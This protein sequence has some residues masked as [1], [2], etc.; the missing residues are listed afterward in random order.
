MFDLSRARTGVSYSLPTLLHSFLLSLTL[1]Y[2]L[3][4]SLA[5]SC[6]LLLS[7]AL[8]CPRLLSLALSCSLLLSLALFYSLLLSLHSSTNHPIPLPL[9]TLDRTSSSHFPRTFPQHAGPADLYPVRWVDPPALVIPE[10]ADDKPHPAT[11]SDEAAG[12]DEMGDAADDE[13]G[14]KAFN[15]FAD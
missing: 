5:L 7:L 15:P 4:L 1:P 9:R 8:S 6:S 11:P 3:L 14:E 2:S 13:R 12:P 10:G